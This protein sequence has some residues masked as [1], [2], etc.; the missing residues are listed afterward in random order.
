M[1]EAPNDGLDQSH[2]TWESMVRDFEQKLD[3]LSIALQEV[4]QAGRRLAQMQ[5]A[6][7]PEGGA[8]SV[9][10]LVAAVDQ[11]TSPDMALRPPATL[12][13]EEEVARDEVRR[14]VEQARQDLE[15]GG[16][17]AAVGWTMPRDFWPG[18]TPAAEPASP[19][20]P[21]S[22]ASK[23]DDPARDE[24]RRAVEQAKAEL[25]ADQAK[26]RRAA[27]AEPVHEPVSSASSW[28]NMN[29]G[30]QGLGNESLAEHETPPQEIDEEAMREAVRLA[31]ERARLEMESGNSSE[32]GE[33]GLVAAAQAEE[34]AQREEVRRAVAQAKAEMSWSLQPPVDADPDA[35]E[36]VD[37]EDAK[38]DEVRR[39]V[40]M[41]RAEMS[42]EGLRMYD[43]TAPPEGGLFAAF[44]GS[45]S[46][47]P[48]WQHN[49]DAELAGL[50]AS[51]VIED[52]VGRV[53][54]ARVYDTLS[55]VDRSSASLLNYTPHSVTV[56]L[57][58]MESLPDTKV[59][60]QAIEASFG[61]VCRVTMDG[62]RMSVKIGETE[63]A[64]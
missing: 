38:R 21:A 50:P 11:L 14:T 26:P 18:V 55:R 3:S 22:P 47:T 59:M 52:P 23:E 8:Q 29:L 39:A 12:A 5:L 40:E 34:E 51:I 42:S 9:A 6:L 2:P 60:T 7:E 62:S 25:A 37:D 24:V 57:A 48:T 64:A 61:R 15:T 28:T 41:A 45:D 16:R 49:K 63:K 32:S 53:E 33:R 54:L 27:H 44:A 30:D 31:V 19:A 20:P 58:A 4:R 10:S 17:M 56:G 13:S 35:P 36:H 43:E 1:T 46:N